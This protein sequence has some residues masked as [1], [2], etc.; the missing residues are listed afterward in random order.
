MLHSTANPLKVKYGKIECLFCSGVFTDPTLF[1]LHI[2]S[3]RPTVNRH[4]FYSVVQSSRT[5]LRVDIGNLRCKKCVG[6]FPCLTTLA[7]HLIDEHDV[8]IQPD[9]DLGLAPL[10]LEKDRFVCIICE[11]VFNSLLT[12]YR[13]SGAHFMSF[14]CDECGKM[15]SS[16]IHLKN[17]KIL[18]HQFYCRR[19]HTKFP[20]AED[21]KLHFKQ[22]KCKPYTTC[23]ICGL[24]FSCADHK[25]RHMEA[26]HGH[27]KAVH[28]CNICIQEFKSRIALYFHFKESHTED[29]KCEDCDISFPTKEKFIEHKASHTG[30]NPYQC[31]VCGKGFSK[32]KIFREHVKIH[33]D[34][35]KFNCT[36]C[37]KLFVGRRK[38]KNHLKARH[39]EVYMQEFGEKP[40]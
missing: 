39:P 29:H 11:K 13:H 37:G 18:T 31:T 5:I 24:D 19:C 17:H 2:D 32:A 38:L 4:K 33:D 36:A 10:L 9:Y 16:P 8:K 6:T 22:K 3:E 7:R 30:E 25:Q 1:K 15:C 14:E 28:R 12:L 34:S 23:S 20:S 35:K 40:E 26:V 27:A 21:R